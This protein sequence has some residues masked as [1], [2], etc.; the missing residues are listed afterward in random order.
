[1][2]VRD[3]LYHYLSVPPTT[4]HIGML[5]VIPGEGMPSLRHHE[6]GDLFLK[7]HVNFPE[8]LDPQVLPLLERAL[9]HRTPLPSFDKS[10]VLEEAALSD[11][12]ARQQ[13]ESSRADRDD[14]M[15]EDEAG[16]PKV[17]CTQ[18]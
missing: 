3:E 10:T 13:Q 8:T 4:I 12:D 2:K 11:L 1:M 6:H 7:F 15:D 18:Q 16:E 14:A 5:K 9:P 17:A